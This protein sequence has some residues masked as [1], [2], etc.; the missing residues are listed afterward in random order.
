MPSLPPAVPPITTLTLRVV[1]YIHEESTDYAVIPAKVQS[2]Q[3]NG[4]LREQVSIVPDS[5][6]IINLLEHCS[7]EAL[8]LFK[9][10]TQT[11]DYSNLKITPLVSLSNN[12][13]SKNS[14]RRLT[15]SEGFL[16]SEPTEKDLTIDLLSEAIKSKTAGKTLHLKLSLIEEPFEDQGC[17]H[18]TYPH[19]CIVLTFTLHTFYISRIINMNTTCTRSLYF[20]LVSSSLISR[21]LKLS[22]MGCLEPTEYSPSWEVSIVFLLVLLK[23]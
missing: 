12:S 7:D 10:A 16:I 20:M 3:L 19:Y 9:T 2:K 14:L 21:Y 1:E 13:T 5:N 23:S 6:G 22:L 8:A 17:L 18:F 11:S 4:T 15:N